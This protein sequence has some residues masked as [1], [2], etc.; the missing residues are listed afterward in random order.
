MW[1]SINHFLLTLPM[2]VM[3]QDCPSFVLDTEEKRMEFLNKPTNLVPQGL[4]NK[5]MASPDANYTGNYACH[6]NIGTG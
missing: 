4:K 6:E 5:V 3:S 2:L 1:T